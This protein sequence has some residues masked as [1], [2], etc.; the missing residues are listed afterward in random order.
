MELGL[1]AVEMKVKSCDPKV[2]VNSRKLEV[3]T[4][5]KDEPSVKK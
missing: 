4:Q 5:K 1:D 2:L 3:C